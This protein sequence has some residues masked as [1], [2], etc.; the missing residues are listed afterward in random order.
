MTPNFKTL[1][2]LSGGKLELLLWEFG[3]FGLLILLIEAFRGD[4]SGMSDSG[5]LCSE[6]MSF[7]AWEGRVAINSCI[8]VSCKDVF[9]HLRA[10]NLMRSS[11][12]ELDP[13]IEEVVSNPVYESINPLTH[14]LL[15]SV[16]RLLFTCQRNNYAF[17]NPVVLDGSIYFAPESQLF[18]S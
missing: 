8:E 16:L 4:A 17:Y 13:V 7:F 10:L 3:L 18:S 9:D 5:Y 1:E 11:F 6:H 12:G 2:L 14:G 15:E